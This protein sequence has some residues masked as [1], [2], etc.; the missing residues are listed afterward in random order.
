[1]LDEK[2]AEP[3]KQETPR[4]LA[5]TARGIIEQDQ[6]STQKDA[7][8]VPE[9][10]RLL[11]VPEVCKLLGIAKRTLGKYTSIGAIPTQTLGRVRVYDAVEIEAYIEAGCPTT[12][13]AAEAIRRKV[14]EERRR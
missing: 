8:Q 14:C 7:Q 10:R 1:M 12:P 11:R 13:G 5:G 4:E 9:T 2:R 6:V 3:Q